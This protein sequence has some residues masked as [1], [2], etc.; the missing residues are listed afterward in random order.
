MNAQLETDDDPPM[1]FKAWYVFL[2]R[3][4]TTAFGYV[5]IIL[6]LLAESDG[7]FSHNALK[8]IVLINGILTAVLGHYNTS[9]LKRQG[10]MQS[11]KSSQP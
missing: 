8:A 3:R 2:W 4:R 7:V 10:A 9:L 11:S 1:S 5:G 6:G